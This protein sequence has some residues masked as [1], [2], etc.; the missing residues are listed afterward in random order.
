MCAAELCQN[1][2]RDQFH[3]SVIVIFENST[4]SMYF[5]SLLLKEL[6]NQKKP[7]YILSLTK[8]IPNFRTKYTGI[9]KY[10]LLEISSVDKFKESI[11]TMRILPGWNPKAN[12]LIVSFTVFKNSKMIANI[13]FNLLLKEDIVPTA[14]VL[15]DQDTK[16]FNIFTTVLNAK[17]PTSI[18]CRRVV[19]EN[20]KY[21]HTTFSNNTFKRVRAKFYPFPP[22][23]IYNGTSFDMKHPGIEIKLLRTL[24]QTCNLTVE[25]YLSDPK[26][27]KGEVFDNGTLTKDFKELHENKY[28]VITGGY[29]VTYPR[30]LYLNPSAAYSTDELIWCVPNSQYYKYNINIQLVVLMVGLLIPVVLV[31]LIWYANR[32]KEARLKFGTSVEGIILN[33]FSICLFVAIPQLPKTD[34]LRYLVGLLIIFAFFCT[35]MFT[36]TITS[37]FIRKTP[38]QKFDSMEKLYKSNLKTYYTTNTFH[39]FSHVFIPGISRAELAQRKIDCSDTLKCL[40]AVAEGDSAVVI[41]KYNVE[42]LMMTPMKWLG[43]GEGDGIIK[44]EMD[45][46]PHRTQDDAAVGYIFQRPPDPEFHSFGPKQQRWAGDEGIIDNQHDQKWKYPTVVNN[47]VATPPNSISYMGSAGAAAAAAM[48]PLYDMGAPNI[49]KTLQPHEQQYIYMP[50]Q[51]PPPPTAGMPLHHAPYMPP[52][53]LTQQ[54]HQQQQQ[55]MRH[56]QAQLGD[57]YRSLFTHHT[58]I[59]PRS[60][61]FYC[62]KYSVVHIVKLAITDLFWLTFCSVQGVIRTNVVLTRWGRTQ[63]DMIGLLIKLRNRT[64]LTFNQTFPI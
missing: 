49:N 9:L 54:L 5:R 19:K 44:V 61:K 45:R 56:Q 17:A 18:A 8:S 35:T 37:L 41:S 7:Y 24:A 39:Y 59:N 58:K 25:Y 21:Y 50:N 14:V 16:A 51:M 15:I 31:V 10:L 60:I 43:G 6:S 36:T 20:A 13:I 28:D 12:F 38:S 34:R 11:S 22:F 4:K 48:A 64:F 2:F 53:S 55:Q 26:C 62:R 27:T 29:V 32:S 33:S 47:K 23:V 63:I 3:N 52:Q 30:A 40:N 42:Y 1:D 57:P 46:G